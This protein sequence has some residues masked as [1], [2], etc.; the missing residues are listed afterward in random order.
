MEGQKPTQPIIY[1]LEAGECKVERKFVTSLYHP[2]NKGEIV[3]QKVGWVTLCNIGPGTIIGEE[4][5]LQENGE[6]VYE[7]RVTV[8]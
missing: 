4:I 8:N 7:Y 1:V 5:L 2:F 6:E 3:Q